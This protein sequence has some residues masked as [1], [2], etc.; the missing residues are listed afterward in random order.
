MGKILALG[1]FGLCGIFFIFA[2]SDAIFGD[3]VSNNSIDPQELEKYFR[4]EDA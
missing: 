3:S 1:F 4:D 2:M